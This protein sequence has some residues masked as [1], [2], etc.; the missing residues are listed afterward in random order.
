[1]QRQILMVAVALAA[2]LITGCKPFWGPTVKEEA[3]SAEELYKKA[4]AL[5]KDKDYDAAIETYQRLKSGHSEFEKAPEVYMRIADAYYDSGKL[6]K[7]ASEYLQFVELYPGNEKVPRANFRVAMCYFKQIK[8]TDRDSRAVTVAA[9]RF[10]ALRDNPDAGEWAKKASE[11][12]DECLKKLAEKELYKAQT[13][14]SMGKY[15]AAR[16]AAKRVLEEYGKLGLDREAED[17][18]KSIKGK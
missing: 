12:Y 14:I 6:E 2:L 7:A 13:Y 3:P 9:E 16:M 1:M 18:I 15:K 4:E 11:K 17:L 5:Y 8:S 10:K